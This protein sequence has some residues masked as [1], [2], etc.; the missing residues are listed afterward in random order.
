MIQCKFQSCRIEKTKT[1]K[2]ILESD[3]CRFR[4]EGFDCS[5][6]MVEKKIYNWVIFEKRFSCLRSH[7]GKNS[8]KIFRSQIIVS[9]KKIRTFYAIVSR[10]NKTKWPHVHRCIIGSCEI[11]CGGFFREICG[12]GVVRLYKF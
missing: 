2:S 11:M 6:S 10:S 5:L 3:P 4:C 1:M 12:C 8:H 9:V 7:G